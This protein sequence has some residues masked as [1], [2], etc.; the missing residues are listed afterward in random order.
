MKQ[1]AWTDESYAELLQMVE[2]QDERFNQ[3]NPKTGFTLMFV[4]GFLTCMAAFALV[5]L[6]L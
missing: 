4:A 3:T 2:E 6:A 1:K 5:V